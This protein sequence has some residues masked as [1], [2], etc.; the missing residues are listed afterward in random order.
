MHE[1]Q[2]RVQWSAFVIMYLPVS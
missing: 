1:V 2:D